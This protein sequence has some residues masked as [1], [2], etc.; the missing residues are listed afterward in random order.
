MWH[1]KFRKNRYFWK[2]L[3][4][5]DFFKTI[6][7]LKVFQPKKSQHFLDLNGMILKMYTVFYEIIE[8][9]WKICRN[10][11]FLFLYVVDASLSRCDS[12]WFRHRS[13][14]LGWVLWLS[15]CQS[16]LFEWCL[17]FF[18]LCVFLAL[19]YNHIWCFVYWRWIFCWFAFEITL[20]PEFK[21]KY[22]LSY[23]LISLN[24]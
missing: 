10:K 21:F 20:Y 8:E 14:S 13:A 4:N 24:H 19:A 22:L 6:G 12:V 1:F 9:N 5:F 23:P 3:L 7:K 17:F 16:S 2:K 18:L 15:I 11:L